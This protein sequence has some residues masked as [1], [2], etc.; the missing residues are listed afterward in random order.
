MNHNYRN[1]NAP[2]K[3]IIVNPEVE[4]EAVTDTEHF[5]PLVPLL[6]LSLLS[7]SSSSSMMSKTVRN[8]LKGIPVIGDYVEQAE[9]LG[10]GS[11]TTLPIL[12]SASICCCC[13]IF[14]VIMI[15]GYF[16]WT[17]YGDYLGE[18]APTDTGYSN[19]NITTMTADFPSVTRTSDFSSAHIGT[20]ANGFP[21]ITTGVSDFPSTHI[22]TRTVDL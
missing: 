2:Y 16:M 9:K 4:K 15:I 21:S 17:N 8:W 22:G 10:E 5:V 1:K 12:I 11:K 20:R 7:A 3:E 6:P 18:M 13:I 19:E 14:I